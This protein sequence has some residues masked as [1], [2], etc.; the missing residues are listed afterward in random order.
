MLAEVIGKQEE[1]PSMKITVDE[2]VNL[3]ALVYERQLPEVL[4]IEDIER[5]LRISHYTSLELVKKQEFPSLKIGK[6]H[7]IPRDEFFRWLS[8]SAKNKSNVS[9]T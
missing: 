5:I 4:H 1:T 7:K 9:I 3:L 6:Y 2:M 8:E